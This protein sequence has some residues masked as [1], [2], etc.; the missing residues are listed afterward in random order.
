M[1]EVPQNHREEWTLD[2]LKTAHLKI[3]SEGLREPQE[4]RGVV[5]FPL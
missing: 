2:K 3:R 1:D 4:I 5:E